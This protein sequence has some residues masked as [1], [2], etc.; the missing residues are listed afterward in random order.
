MT[1]ERSSALQSSDEQVEK[2]GKLKTCNFLINS[3]KYCN[4]RWN[5]LFWAI[6][7]FIVMFSKVVCN[8]RCQMSSVW[9]YGLKPCLTTY[10]C[11]QWCLG[12]RWFLKKTLWQKEKLLKTSYF[13]IFQCF[14]LLWVNFIFSGSPLDAYVAIWG[15][16]LSLEIVRHGVMNRCP[17]KLS[18]DF[19]W[20]HKF[21]PFPT[22]NKPA[23][24]NFEPNPSSFPHVYNKYAAG[25]FK[26][27]RQSLW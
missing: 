15:K 14:Y 8:S 22:Y 6:S 4:K 5:C 10:R 16:S 27:S 11:F 2:S 23:S 25:S 3:W 12:S 26:R 20:C 19:H 13:S 24:N 7:P 17:L 9:S 21:K 1:F 18:S